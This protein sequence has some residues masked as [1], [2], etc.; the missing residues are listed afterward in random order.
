M[1]Q[2]T[3]KY[4]ESSLLLRAAAEKFSAGRSEIG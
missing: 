3:K 4:Q 1:S 2:Q